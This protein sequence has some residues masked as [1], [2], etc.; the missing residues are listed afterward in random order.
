VVVCPCSWCGGGV[1]WFFDVL[2]RVAWDE[3]EGWQKMLQVA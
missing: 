3:Q 1:G 2:Q